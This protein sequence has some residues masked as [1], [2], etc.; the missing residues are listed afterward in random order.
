MKKE[1]VLVGTYHFE[2]NVEL[3]GKKEK[4]VIELVDHLAHYK[5]TKVAVEWGKSADKELNLKYR[6]SNGDF[7]IDEIQQIGFRL[8]KKL[9][10]KNVY[11]VNWTGGGLPRKIWRNLMPQFNVHILNY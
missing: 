1:I 6:K 11:A 5:P 8:A 3:V 2:Q 9:N 7:S 4:E 10:H